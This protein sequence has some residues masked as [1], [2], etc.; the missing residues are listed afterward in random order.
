M[1]AYDDN[2]KKYIKLVAVNNKWN[3]SDT[4]V[5]SNPDQE[6]ELKPCTQ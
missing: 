3:Y 4:T 6:I 5:N 2:T 1:I